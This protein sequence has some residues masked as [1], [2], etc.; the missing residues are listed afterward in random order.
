MISPL[1]LLRPRCQ[2][3]TRIRRQRHQA[4]EQGGGTDGR[5]RHRPLGEMWTMTG[6]GEGRVRRR[7]QT[8][9]RGRLYWR[10]WFNDDDNANSKEG[11][12]GVGDNQ[13]RADGGGER[14]RG[15]ISRGRR[16]CGRQ[17]QQGAWGWRNGRRPA[18]AALAGVEASHPHPDRSSIFIF[19]DHVSIW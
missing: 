17:G 9:R 18:A 6:L 3:L 12:G 7:G 16:M 5:H 11:G 15:G 19:L 8:R 1:F 2:L 4:E 10:G 13:L 14:G